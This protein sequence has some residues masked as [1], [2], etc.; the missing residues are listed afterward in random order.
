MIPTE[1]AKQGTGDCR[2]SGSVRGLVISGSLYSR[3]ATALLLTQMPV[4][5]KL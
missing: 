4:D 5:E 1:I 3:I 2:P